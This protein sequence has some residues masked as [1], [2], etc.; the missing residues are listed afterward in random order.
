MKGI[1]KLNKDKLFLFDPQDFEE[2]VKQNKNKCGVHVCYLMMILAH[3][4]NDLSQA[5]K[6]DTVFTR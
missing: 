1:R 5:E 4:S 3:E 6:K 2:K